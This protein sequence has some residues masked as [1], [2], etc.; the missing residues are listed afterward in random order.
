MF[1]SNTTAMTKKF[2]ITNLVALICGLSSALAMY[3]APSHAEE[4]KHQL[5]LERLA[6]QARQHAKPV[7]SG[8]Q[9]PPK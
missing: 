4:R 2:V 8:H 9:H 6:Q 1:G 7:P 5:E 3:L